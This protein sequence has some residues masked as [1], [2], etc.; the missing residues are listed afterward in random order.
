MSYVGH[1]MDNSRRLEFKSPIRGP[2]VS[3]RSGVRFLHRQLF[4][5][6]GES[7]IKFKS[8]TDSIEF[9]VNGL[10]AA[11]QAIFILKNIDDAVANTQHFKAGKKK[12]SVRVSLVDESRKR[13]S[14]KVVATTATTY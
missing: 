7:D 2:G 3:G 9:S 14:H 12:F 6:H 10:D 1:V 11:L 5:V 13:K 8:K 4:V